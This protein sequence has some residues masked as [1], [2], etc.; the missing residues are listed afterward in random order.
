MTAAL[1]LAIATLAIWSAHELGRWRGEEDERARQRARDD[2]WQ[3]IR[4]NAGTHID[5]HR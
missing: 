4:R 2:W 5:H 1:I 3:T